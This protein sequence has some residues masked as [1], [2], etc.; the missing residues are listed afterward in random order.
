MFD[1]STVDLE[2]ILQR[3]YE[4]MSPLQRPGVAKGRSSRRV[5]FAV[6][7]GIGKTFM[8]LT[9]GLCFKPQTWLIIGTK[10]SINAFKNEIDKW[11][12]EFSNDELYVV[13]RGTELERRLAYQRPGL[14]Y[15]T[16]SAAFIRDAKWLL[17]KKVK[18]D[19]ITVDELQRLGYRNHKSL[20][21]KHTKD[22]IKH[23]EKL[24][25]RSAIKLINFMTGTWTSKGPPQQFAVLNILAPKLFTSYWRH[26]NTF[27][28]TIKT[29]F[30]TEI[31]GPKNT[32][33]MAQVLSP[34]VYTVTKEEAEKELPPINRLRLVTSL[35]PS[36]REHYDTLYEHMYMDLEGDKGELVTVTTILAAYMKLRQFL[37]CPQIIS[38]SLGVGP[39]IEAVVDKIQEGEE[40]PNYKHNIVFTPFLDSIPI[41]KDYLSAEL[42]IPPAKILVAKG[43]QT[44]EELKEMETQFRRDPSTMILASLLYS[45]SWNAETALSVYFPHFDWDQDANFQAEARSRRQDGI[46]S[47]INAWYIHFPRTIT[48]DMFDI[49]NRKT[50][51]NN[52]TYKDFRII[53]ERAKQRYH[54]QKL[55]TQSK[56]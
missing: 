36:L 51:L 18:F 42:K 41:F 53:A 48:E 9:L 8:A 52:L 6:W 3:S 54:Q 50:N 16:T 37:C 40:L 46:Q 2:A 33:G 49:L 10:G 7:M 12:P 25:G 56:S 17:T 38:P 26:V 45:Q 15:A 14:F 39:A 47:F 28:H 20:T 55:K 32:E 27:C 22:V 23:I 19:V 34:Y 1:Y 13:V 30:G 29:T 31:L 11:F 24:H 21:V 44:I 4:A 35:P 43:G 5:I